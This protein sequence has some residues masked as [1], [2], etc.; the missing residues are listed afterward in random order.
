ME[1]I[2]VHGLE[3]LILRC[4]YSFKKIKNLSKFLSKLQ[5]NFLQ[6]QRI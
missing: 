4:Q 6:K 5:L 3:D 1:R 2:Y